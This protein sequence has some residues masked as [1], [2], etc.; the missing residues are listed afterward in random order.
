MRARHIAWRLPLIA[1]AVSLSLAAAHADEAQVL[2]PFSSASGETPPASWRFETLPHKVPTR[3]TVV[4]LDGQR[5]L[6]VQADGSYGLLTQRVQ[7][8]LNASTTLRWRWRVDQF[9]QGTNLHTRDGDDGIAKLCVFFNLPP[10]KLS[11]ADRTRLAAARTVSGEDVPSEALCYVWD[12]TEPKGEL[13]T[14]AFTDR[15]RMQVIESGPT[16]PSGGWLS[17]QRNL[18]ADYRRAFG[19]EAQGLMPNVVAITVAAD[20]DNTL[21][22]GVAYFGDPSLTAQ[23]DATP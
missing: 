12:G 21:G 23:P 5:V 22:H 3:F 16:A 15:M 7:V 4:T 6:K 11:L 17:E 10:D 2:T 14:N 13:L 18:L 1:A 9:I 8:P 19:A 20:A